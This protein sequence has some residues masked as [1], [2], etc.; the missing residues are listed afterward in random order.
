MHITI[1]SLGAV[2]I[3][4]GDDGTVPID[5]PGFLDQLKCHGCQVVARAWIKFKPAFE[6]SDF[7]LNASHRYLNPAKELLGEDAG[8]EDI[9]AWTK[10]KDGVWEKIELTLL[11]VFAE[12]GLEYRY[13]NT[14]PELGDTLAINFTPD[15]E[16]GH[17]QE[18]LHRVTQILGKRRP[19]C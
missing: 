15:M 7:H 8:Y 4:K 13:D 17:V 19:T 5:T 18:I 1:N 6:G 10:L 2:R 9:F 12:L 3:K 11:P 14:M 16:V